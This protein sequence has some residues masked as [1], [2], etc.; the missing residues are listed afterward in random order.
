MNRSISER[1][2]AMPASPI[3]KL[4]PFADEAKARGTTV[5]HLN[6]GQPDVET[7][8]PAL[9][10]LGGFSGKV[11]SYTHS[12]GVAEYLD[13]LLAYYAGHGIELAREQVNVTTGGSEAI[14]FGM[15]GAMNPGEEIIVPEPFYTNYS[16]FARMAGVTVVPLTTRGEDGFHLPPREA[17]DSLVTPKT[18]A[19]LICNPNN[20]TGT[21][22]TSA[23]IESAASIARER[24][25]WFFCDEV[26]REFIFD[27]E[28]RP[29]TSALNLEGLEDR[30]VVMDSISKRF[31]MCGARL[32]CI[33]SRNAAL[34]DAVL[35]MAQ[36]RL[37]SPE[38]EQ[39]M[40]VEAH[41]MPASYMDGV[42]DEYRRRRDIVYDELRKIPGVK[43]A[44]PEGAFYTIPRLPV[45]DTE[46]FA[47]WLLTDFDFEG[48]TVM[49]APAAGFYATP[50]LG[51]D[52]IRIAFVLNCDSLRRAMRILGRA[53]EVYN[54]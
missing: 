30:V 42:I 49:V 5:Y 21:V 15:L 45:K 54:R 31:S 33:V 37:S 27:A 52:E 50:G 26:Y 7:P 32:G 35:K 39:V 28:N 3:R 9:D 23:E 51:M 47:K 44:R 16:G 2:A 53:L 19:I 11:V 18:S 13:E 17:I 40:A 34:M 8:G 43:V 20:P 10:A 14:L 36:A 25:L 24:D 12:Q 1:G 29:H 22:Y 4:V 6:I 48:E 46:E 38:V 41:R